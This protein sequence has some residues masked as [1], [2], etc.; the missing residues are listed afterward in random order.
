MN[1]SY[2]IC[3]SFFTLTRFLSRNFTLKSACIYDK[4]G[5]ATKHEGGIGKFIPDRF[6]LGISR[7]KRNLVD[8]PT[9]P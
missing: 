6:P 8:F 9:P 3:V 7:D 1:S 2:L 4:K 5:L